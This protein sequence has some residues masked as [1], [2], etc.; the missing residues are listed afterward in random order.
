MSLELRA[1]KKCYG[2]KIVLD[3]VNLTL[4]PGKIYGLIGR[5][6]AG[7]TTMLSIAS[8]QNPLTEGEVLLDGEKV[9]ENQKALDCICFS[10][11]IGNIINGVQNTIKVKEYLKI[12]SILF[13]KWDQTY[14]DRLV[15]EFELDIK[16]KICKLSKGM[17]SMITIIIAL[18]SKAE[19]TFLDEPVAGLDVVAREDFYK[20]LLDEYGKSG[21][22]FVIS[23]H[24]IEEATDVFEEVIF[25]D[26]GKILIKENTVDLLER[27]VHISGRADDVDAVVE[28]KN[29]Y[30]PEKSGRGKVVTVLLPKDGIFDKKGHDVDVSSMTLQ[31]V[32][33]AFCSKSRGEEE[34]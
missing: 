10:R 8:A 22:T 2:K 17:Q 19:Y 28:G 7:K 24:I 5:N 6:G 13:P 31:E 12:A 32:F 34:E 1:V 30:H 14:A 23:T 33:V 3:G 11:E 29:V 27:C 16:Q 15:K 25:L 21:R 9:W 4:E 26:K 18:A 20:I